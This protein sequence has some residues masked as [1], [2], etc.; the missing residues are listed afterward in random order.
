MGL[1]VLA[2]A[3]LEP[4]LAG[5]PAPRPGG[6]RIDGAARADIA[7]DA[8][9]ARLAGESM[10]ETTNRW[11]ICNGLWLRRP[12]RFCSAEPLNAPNHERA[13]KP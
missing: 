13:V 2:A 10:R 11:G 9:R 12:A 5:Q 7:A 8:G 4:A 6:S 1:L 3:E